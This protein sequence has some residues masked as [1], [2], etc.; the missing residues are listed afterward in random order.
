MFLRPISDFNSQYQTKLSDPQMV[1]R[2]NLIC[3]KCLFGSKCQQWIAMGHLIAIGYLTLRQT[4]VYTRM[5]KK[6]LSTLNTLKAPK[7]CDI[8]TL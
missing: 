1:R 2:P 3:S 7:K 6:N 5:H 4:G 8:V